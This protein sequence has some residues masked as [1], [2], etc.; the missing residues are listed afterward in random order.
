MRN[1]SL[2]VSSSLLAF[3]LIGSLLFSITCEAQQT[4]EPV[5]PDVVNRI[6][7]EELNRS[8]VMATVEYLTDVIGP[9]LTNSPNLRRAQ[10]YAIE[11]LNT[12]GIPGGKLEPWGRNFGRGW[13]LE[14]FSA[15]MSAPGFSSLIAYP[16]AWSP[17]T[18]GVIRGE[19]VWLEVKTESDLLNYKGKLKGKI[20]LNSPARDVAPSFLPAPQ[21]M[22]DE[23]LRKLSEEPAPP[24]GPRRFQMNA[25]QRARAELIF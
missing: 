25:Q 23:Q 24:A 16:K 19:P 9:R 22:T 15:N 1:L 14:T 5:N 4:A 6:K 13:T 8:Q 18:N 20:V 7:D 3:V 17:S 11:R 2:K 12:W 10:Q 21:R